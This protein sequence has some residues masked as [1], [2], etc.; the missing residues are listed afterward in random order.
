MTLYSLGNCY[1]DE[2]NDHVNE[3]NNVNDY[4]MN[5]SK[6][7]SSKSFRYMTKL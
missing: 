3:N 7:S 4:R 1:R 6:A 5:K 2:M